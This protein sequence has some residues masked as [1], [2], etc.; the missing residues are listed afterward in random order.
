MSDSRILQL[1]EEIN[2]I[3]RKHNVQQWLGVL[4]DI[5]NNWKKA[6]DSGSSKRVLDMADE[7][8][9]LYG[10]MGSLTDLYISD[11][12]G[13]DIAP[14]DIHAV[15]SRLQALRHALY[16]EAKR[17]LDDHEASSGE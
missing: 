9:S 13:D 7:I 10:G 11:R 8:L 12:A 15:N 17:K 14:R 2:N 16:L 5:A 6:E 1:L 3:L 4:T